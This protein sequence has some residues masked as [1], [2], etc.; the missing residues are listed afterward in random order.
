[1]KMWTSGRPEKCDLCQRPIGSV[2]IDGLTEFGIW[3]VM[4]LICWEQGGVG[5]GPGKGQKY[6]SETLE[7]ID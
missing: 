3:A 4:C 6:N 5:L 2:F 7:S 1:M